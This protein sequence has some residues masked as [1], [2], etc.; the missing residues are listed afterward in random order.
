M[1]YLYKLWQRGRDFFPIEGFHFDR[2]IVVLQS[3]DWG[4]AGVRDQSGID[5]LGSAGFSLGEH[6]YDLYTLE[7]ADDLTA[8]L[9]LLYRHRDSTGRSA[10]VGM[11]FVVANLNL[12]KMQAEGFRQIHLLPLADGLPQ[13]WNRAGLL[14][15]YRAGIG[16]GVFRPALH[17]VTHFC[18]AAV[19][20]ELLAGSQRASLLRSLWQAGTPYIHWRTPWIGYEYWDPERRADERFLPIAAQAELIGQAVGLFSKMFSTLPRS[21]CAP[22]Y[23]ANDDTHRAWS[24]FGIKVAQNG[25]RT[26]TPPHLDRHGILNLHRNVEFE[27]ATDPSV[28]IDSC[29]NAAEA[30]F[31]I[32]IPAIVSLHSINFH[33]S[34]S[35]FRD[36]TVDLLNQ[37]LSALEARHPNLLYLHDDDLHQLVEKGFY[38]TAQGTAHMNVTKKKFTRVRVE[39]RKA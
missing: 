30:S 28:S 39:P 2:P 16:S 20:R 1:S 5:D 32:G 18:R 17:G 24:Q 4:R 21:A 26:L 10:S 29:I 14:E 9:D 7:T 3:D 22:G 12:A 23:R 13:G 19:D 36:R 35:G 15:A 25:P 33:S 27:P 11:N 6:P 31:D 37:F 34:V 8:L 38:Q